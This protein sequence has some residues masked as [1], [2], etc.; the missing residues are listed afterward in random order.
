MLFCHKKFFQLPLDISSFLSCDLKKHFNFMGHVNVNYSHTGVFTFHLHIRLSQETKSNK[1]NQIEVL[2]RR[3]F[4]F[5]F[6][7]N[8]V[9]GYNYG[10]LSS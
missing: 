2:F 4:R 9:F 7:Q 10:F 8:T 1:C 5:N 6:L 3:G